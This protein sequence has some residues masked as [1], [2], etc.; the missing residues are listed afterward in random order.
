MIASIIES[1]ENFVASLLDILSIRDLRPLGR[2]YLALC[3]QVKA[4]LE[5]RFP[6]KE[7]VFV[8]GGYTPGK[9][10]YGDDDLVET[11][12][13]FLI[14]LGVGLNVSTSRLPPL[15]IPCSRC[16]ADFIA[17]G[18]IVVSGWV[19]ERYC[20]CGFVTVEL[21]IYDPTT[22]QWVIAPQLPHALRRSYKLLVR[23]TD[24]NTFLFARGDS[25]GSLY[26]LKLEGANWVEVERLRG[27]GTKIIHMQFNACER[28]LVLVGQ[29]SDPNTMPSL[30]K[31]LRAVLYNLT[32]QRWTT[33]GQLLTYR[34]SQAVCV[35]PNGSVVCTGGLTSS[36]HMVQGLIEIK[37]RIEQ[38]CEELIVENSHSMSLPD[39]IVGRFDH[40][41]LPVYGRHLL[42]L[43]GRTSEGLLASVELYD[44]EIGRA[45]V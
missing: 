41:L 34:S 45:H 38:S 33:I 31:G 40:R 7:R 23:S 15:P 26:H 17:D 42:N 28:Q 37:E 8:G 21:F 12:S 13:A 10:A 16:A 3:S 11:Q 36:V 29:H 20:D 9:N 24:V 6:V 39:A 4:S 30:Q 5:R 14:E 22:Q 25:E 2:T 43:G 35:A 18:R 19:A 27:I 1:S 32:T 44:S